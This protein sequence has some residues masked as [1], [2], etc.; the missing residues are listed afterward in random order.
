[1]RAP[2]AARA[3]RLG[4]EC[5]VAEGR[6]SG[7]RQCSAAGG[8][9]SRVD[10]VERGGVCRYQQPMTGRTHAVPSAHFI[11]LD[12]QRE[13]RTS[14]HYL[15]ATCANIGSG[16]ITR[17]SGSQF[18]ARRDAF[19]LREFTR[20]RATH[21]QQRRV[22][23]AKSSRRRDGARTRSALPSLTRTGEVSRCARRSRRRPSHSKTS[24]IT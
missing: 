10:R 13:R 2:S 24:K 8:G 14:S 15:R 4:V 11:S 19:T 17:N 23:Q 16:E 5:R 9:G 18:V 1:M 6:R 22:T 3:G 20:T 21:A 7:R 12:N